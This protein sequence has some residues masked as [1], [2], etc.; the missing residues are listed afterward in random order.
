MIS[1][2]RLALLLDRRGD[3]RLRVVDAPDDRCDPVERAGAGL[4][5]E[6]DPRDRAVDLL[7][8]VGRLP[9][10]G[11]DLV[12]DDREALARLAGALRLDRRV[13]RQQVGLARDLRDH[14]HDLADLLGGRTQ[15]F[16]RSV[17][18]L[19]VGDRPA[20]DVGRLGGAPSDL[21]D[22]RADALRARHRV[23]HVA[24]HLFGGCRDVG[25]DVGR[26]LGRRARSR[27][28]SSRAS[29]KSPRASWRRRRSSRSPRRCARPWR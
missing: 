24:R 17:D 12:G 1:P 10:E 4:D 14:R 3:R 29:P 28:S 2:G 18:V 13:E 9:G 23:R 11:F 20:G 15:A 19:R 26:L 16:D 25:R 6:A 7:G 27:R 22:R 21:V 5:L 8:R